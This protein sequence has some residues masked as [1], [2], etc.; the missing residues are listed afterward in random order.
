MEG[1]S[2][3]VLAGLITCA[4]F[5]LAIGL[6]GSG[7]GTL[8]AALHDKLPAAVSDKA[9]P[10]PVN[11]ENTPAA[12]KIETEASKKLATRAD[13]ENVSEELTELIT[14]KSLTATTESRFLL[15]TIVSGVEHLKAET[16]KQHDKLQADIAELRQKVEALSAKPAAQKRA[17]KPAPAPP[18]P[19]KELNL[20]WPATTTR[21]LHAVNS[22]V[23]PI[24]ERT[25]EP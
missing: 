2:L 16:E 18:A 17:P 19:K 5:A 3:R 8:K 9:A 21:T 7:L 22:G 4:A 14:T 23:P 15:K 24:T 11:W 13:L 20:P 12:R 10:P 25:G 1:R 6:A